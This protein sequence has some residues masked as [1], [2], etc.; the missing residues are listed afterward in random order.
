MIFTPPRRPTRD[1]RIAAVPWIGDY[2]CGPSC[3]PLRDAHLTDARLDELSRDGSTLQFEKRLTVIR[4]TQ[5]FASEH[6]SAE[7]SVSA[8]QDRT[9]YRNLELQ[10]CGSL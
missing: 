2:T 6:T 8:Q 10:R 9:S 3:R 5:T 4:S 7:K 1:L